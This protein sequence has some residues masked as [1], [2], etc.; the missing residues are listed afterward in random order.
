MSVPARGWALA[1]GPQKSEWPTLLVT[2]LDYA[3]Q[4]TYTFSYTV[5]GNYLTSLLLKTILANHVAFF[6]VETVSRF[7]RRE[8]ISQHVFKIGSRAHAYGPNS[9]VTILLTSPQTVLQPWSLE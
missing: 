4:F 8:G 9:H 5:L 3:E 6:D 7:V 1:A 2:A